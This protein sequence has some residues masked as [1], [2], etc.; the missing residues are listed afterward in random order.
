MTTLSPHRRSTPAPP[1]TSPVHA[2]TV[3]GGP[4]GGGVLGILTGARAD[5][6]VA[7]H[8]GRLAARTGRKVTA[9]VAFRSR[10]FSVN[11][12]L[13]IARHR[14]LT[15]QAEAVL[16]PHTES[17]AAAGHYRN[18]SVLFPARTNLF[19]RLPARALARFAA[20]IGATTVIT[21]VPLHPPGQYFA[22]VHD[23]SRATSRT[24]DPS[25]PLTPRR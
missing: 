7:A 25:G 3:V 10:G 20:R 17:L 14:R 9:A 6:D 23:A 18:A 15:H 16:A 4:E 21:S 12:L 24:A 8:A 5:A 22:R 1:R 2:Y 13:H 19:H 11:A